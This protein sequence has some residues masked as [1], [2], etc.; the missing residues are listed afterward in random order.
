MHFF[1]RDEDCPPIAAARQLS[2]FKRF[3]RDPNPFESN[4][5]QALTGPCG[6]LLEC[7]DNFRPGV[8]FF[9]VSHGVGRFTERVA[10]IDYRDYFS[11]GDQF[12]KGHQV[13]SIDICNDEFEVLS[14]QE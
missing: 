13:V 7:D 6:F 4:E 12:S 10:S 5:G 8:S 1:T 2:L 14:Q 11:V 3:C 9:C